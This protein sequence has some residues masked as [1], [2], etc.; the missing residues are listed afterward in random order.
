MISGF[1]RISTPSFRLA[2]VSLATLAVALIPS[3]ALAQQNPAP[4]QPAETSATE[5]E[6]II[7]TGSRLSRS[8]FDSPQ[9]VTVL[10]AEQFEELQITNVG[11]G[12][13]E[14]PAFRPSNNPAT[15]GFGSFNV[16]AQIVNLR[17]LG[18]NRNLVL[19]D[20]R[21]FA[22]TT[23]EGSVDLNF[24]PSTLVSRVEVVTGGASAAYGSDALAGAVNVVLDTRLEGFKAQIDYG[25]SQ[26]NDGENLHAGAAFGTAFA[27]GAGHFVIGGE[28]SDQSKVG[29]C[30][31]RDWC[32]VG[33]VVT[34]P[35][36]GASTASPNGNGLPQYVRSDDNAGWFLN[37]SGIVSRVNNATGVGNLIANSRGSGA[38]TFGPNGQVLSRSAAI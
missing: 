9:P 8:T 10:G 34:N 35:G 3:A 5:A 7:V 17:G 27:G 14:L 6:L 11:E 33:S 19:V 32:E 13:A 38:I 22:P 18:V 26:E 31:T 24:I 15:N 25:I 12:I 37:N 29:S 2:Q 30:F 16:G 36:F 21:R 23:R 28:Y 1:G 20:G 4:R